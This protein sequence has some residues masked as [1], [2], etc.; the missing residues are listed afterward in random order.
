MNGKM[1]KCSHDEEI[2]SKKFRKR[3]SC[4]DCDCKEFVDRHNV[5]HYVD[6]AVSLIVGGFLIVLSIGMFVQL[7][8]GSGILGPEEDSTLTED[9][10]LFVSLLP[11]IA[12]V[13]ITVM[14]LWVYSDTKKARSRWLRPARPEDV[15]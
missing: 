7:F 1:C 10:I 11:L 15:Q 5:H 14:V 9:G 3:G 13:T 6:F 8:L 12:S 4:I 2:H